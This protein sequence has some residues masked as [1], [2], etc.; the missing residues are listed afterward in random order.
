ISMGIE[1]A[2]MVKYT[3][4][5]VLATKISFINEM[6]NLCEL[7]GA[8]INDVRQ[9]IGHDQRIGF[10]FFQPGVGYG[11]S[12]FPKDV[13]ALSS[14]AGQH[15]FNTRIL[16]SVDET[17]TQQKSVL[18]QKLLDHFDC[19]LA[20]RTVAIWG[21]AFKPETDDI[22]EAPA[23]VLIDHLLD[24]GAKVRVHDPVAME[25]VKA[26]YG[27]RIAYCQEQYETCQGAEALC[28]L[29]EWDQYRKANYQA[30]CSLMKSPVI[31]DG[32]NLFDP[33]SMAALG[34]EYE[35]IGL[36]KQVKEIRQ[37]VQQIQ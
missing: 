36:L 2:E 15:G 35:G 20:G 4:N 5:C 27:D 25:N 8:D 6:A 17:N 28:I 7:I 1:S 9:G 33:E 3:A 34:I 23:L 31:L 18:F 14:I 19:D 16:K 10:S 37:P 24:I 13:R 30:A 29:T 32:R 26:L 12:C 21:L 11:G 22:R